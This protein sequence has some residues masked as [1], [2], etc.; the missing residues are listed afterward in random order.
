[1]NL[2][3]VAATGAAVGAIHLGFGLG[4][5]A[6]LTPLLALLIDPADALTIMSILAWVAQI[7][8]ARRYG[9]AWR[10]DCL[11]WL[12]P[13]TAAGM[14]LG[15]LLLQALP[16]PLVSRI[17]GVAAVAYGLIQLVRLVRDRQ[18]LRLAPPPL[19]AV[20][21]GLAAGVTGALANVDGVLVS[22]FL[23]AH[24]LEKQQFITTMNLYLLLT[25]TWKLAIF[26][27][28]GVLP[29]KVAAGTLLVA[30]AVLLGGLAGQAVNGRLSARQFNVGVAFLVF[31]VGFLLTLR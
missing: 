1:M 17:I 12:V 7:V 30:P 11:R 19:L 28:M 15:T 21:L 8:A 22:M 10:W 31:L 29:W 27:A 9:R 13:A 3:L 23:L 14:L 24:G 5:G 6:L 25:G 16:R 4:A 20:P 2:L 26:L 18:P